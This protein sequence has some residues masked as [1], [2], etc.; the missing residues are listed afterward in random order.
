MVARSFTVVQILPEL[1]SGG[2]ERGTLEMGK[3]LVQLG[4]RSIVISGG[5]RLVSQLESEGSEHVLWDIGKKNPLTLR[6]ISKLRTFLTEQKVDILHLRSRM[7]AWIGYMAWKSLAKNSRPRLVTTFHG[8]YSVSSYSAVMTKGEK[9]IAISKSVKRHIQNTYK[10]PEDRIV[11]IHRGVDVDAFHPH[12]ISP[13]KVES[14]MN[15]WGLSK[16]AKAV[17]MLPGRITRLKGHDVFIKALKKIN[18][19]NWLAVCVGDVDENPR[20]RNDLQK[21]SADLQLEDR[22][23]F[24]GHCDNM[25][26]AYLLADIVVSATSTKPEAFGRIAAEAQAMGRP[27]IASAHGGSLET[28]LPGKTGWL[29]K[30]DDPQSLADAL[31]EALDDHQ[32]LQRFGENGIDWVHQNFSTLRMCEETVSLYCD[33]LRQREELSRSEKPII[34]GHKVVVEKTDEKFIN[35]MHLLPELIEGGVERHV[36][37]L[38]GQQQKDGH[39]VNV[40]SA[41][42]KLVSQLAKGVSHI[43]F[44]IH[45]KNPLV[46][47][48]CAVRLASLVRKNK[49]DVIHAHSR[50][51]AWIAM[52]TS[53]FSGKPY[54]VTAHAYFSTQTQWIYIPYRQANTVLCVSKAVQSGMKNCFSENTVVIRNG[55]PAVKITWKGSDGSRVN[56]LFVG[57]LTQLKGLQDI[58]EIAPSI[59]NNW[60]LDVLGDGPLRGKLEEMVTSLK[61][62]E[63]VIFHGFQDDPDVWMERSDCLLFPSYI[64]GMPLTLARA[65]QMGLPVIASDIEPVS[66]MTLGRNGLVKPGDLISWKNA[67]ERFLVTRQSPA[68]FDKNAIPTIL[69]MT[70][71][72]QS[73]YDSVISPED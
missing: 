64:E 31:R 52:F 26:V 24:V 27:V 67:I 2:V 43:R 21:L 70:Q 41:G 23:K 47:I 25:P 45:L 4:H 34:T 29:V 20:Y 60:K 35:I 44:P 61:L 12:K 6:Y 48:Y 22:I 17:V 69:Q 62:E 54:I 11:L 46:G 37:M 32:Q 57:R 49:I 38:S 3:Y 72:V 39:K 18:D 13:E 10:V 65:V 7:P 36:L 15:D 8:F 53:K 14:L 63:K 40:V 5:G 19:L 50:V 51:P 16:N 9:I 71:E 59:Q 68:D 42:G 30:P 28:V 66:E 58:L 1:E 73:V 33:L 55:L 56:F